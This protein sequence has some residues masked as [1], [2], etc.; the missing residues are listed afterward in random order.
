METS[1]P[2][3]LVLDL[4][5]TSMSARDLT[6]MITSAL[7]AAELRA[8]EK[9]SMPSEGNVR[10]G[11]FSA[12]IEKYSHV[13]AGFP[14]D[15]RLELG[16]GQYVD[17]SSQEADRTH[18]RVM[19][20]T[21]PDKI[22]PASYAVLLE[23][24]VQFCRR[25]M[26]E[27]CAEAAFQY[28][29]GGGAKCLPKTPLVGD[30]S[31]VVITTQASVEAAYDKPAVFWSAGWSHVEQT[32]D[33]YLLQR[34]MDT[35]CSVDYLRA[36][37]PHQ[38]ALARGAKPKQTRYYLPNPLPEETPILNSGEQ[39]LHAY[40]YHSELARM[41]YTC[42]LEKEAHVGG[43]EILGLYQLLREGKLP[44]GS[45]VS[46]ARVLFY[47]QW[48]AGQEKRPLLDIGAQVAYIAS[49]GKELELTE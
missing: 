5:V 11:D 8:I 30:R 12:A 6:D 20:H 41:E 9:W 3:D 27:A 28:W 40:G 21:K 10:S 47:E 31:H 4:R 16:G 37:L 19:L 33:A 32:G 42:Y 22:K 43:W 34:A 29:V 17:F 14:M 7:A 49:D 1:L 35:T 39:M 44:D 25:W 38:W 15:G 45:P 18:W 23:S 26:Q 13:R 48:M 46:N 2:D 36:V 24:H